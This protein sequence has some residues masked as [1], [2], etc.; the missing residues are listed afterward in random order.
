MKVS[1]ALNTLVS[2]EKPGF[3]VHSYSRWWCV[4][5]CVQLNKSGVL[6]KAID[7]IKY[8]RNSNKRLKHENVMLK[9]AAVAGQR[10]NSQPISSQRELALCHGTRSVSVSNSK[11]KVFPYSFGR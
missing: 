6:R 10:A 7:Y 8:L 1:N 3:R 4:C 5:V 11:G 2:G 9:F